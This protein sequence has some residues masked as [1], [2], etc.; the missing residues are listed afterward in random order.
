MLRA[1]VAL[2]LYVVVVA[3]TFAVRTALQWR[4]YGDTGWRFHRTSGTGVVAQAVLVVGGGL[5]VAASIAAL[6]AGAAHEPLGPAWLTETGTAPAAVSAGTGGVLI[7]GGAALAWVAQ[8][9]MGR[10]WRIGV[11]AAERTEL[12][13]GG[14]FRWVRNPIY[15]GMALCFAGAA[16]LVPNVLAVAALV[17]G[18]IGL[19]IQVRRVEE[20]HLR[21]THGAAYLT[22]AATTGRFVPGLGCLNPEDLDDQATGEDPPGRQPAPPRSPRG[23]SPSRARYR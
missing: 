21:A 10:S 1:Q 12:V 4:R 14:L 5:L 8:R 11:D 17:I 7:V 6:A 23:G 13:T 18:G 9:Q 3:A 16:L 19:E 15:S 2:V 22:W 20:P